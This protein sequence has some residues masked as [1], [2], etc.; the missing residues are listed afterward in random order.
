MKH[1]EA[2]RTLQTVRSEANQVRLEIADLRTQASSANTILAQKEES[3]ASQKEQYERELADLR[4][5]REEVVQQ[6]AHLHNQL[7]TLTKQIGNL[8]RDR[9]QLSHVESGEPAIPGLDDLQ[10]VIKYLR[11]E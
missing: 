10:E 3:F 4:N 8:Q 6:N 1:A 11:R 9:S 2:A 7:E 5:R